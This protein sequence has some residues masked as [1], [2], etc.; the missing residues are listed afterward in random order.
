VSVNRAERLL[1]VDLIR[2][3]GYEEL[4]ECILIHSCLFIR[5]LLMF[6]KLYLLFQ[7]EYFWNCRNW[8]LS[9]LNRL[10]RN[11]DSDLRGKVNCLISSGLLQF[12]S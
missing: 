9:V 11:A 2:I 10:L 7:P 3:T 12:Q 5:I 8:C 1:S 6:G 4:Y